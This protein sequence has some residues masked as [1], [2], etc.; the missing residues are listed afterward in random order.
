MFS[1]DELSSKITFGGYDLEKFA[2]PEGELNFHSITSSFRW[3]LNFESI[4]LRFGEDSDLN[5]ETT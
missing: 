2:H 1:D 5:R 3:N 4:S